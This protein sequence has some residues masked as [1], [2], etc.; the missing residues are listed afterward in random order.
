MR[1]PFLALTLTSFAAPLAAKGPLFSLPIDCDLGETC[2][3]QN[4]VDT[5]PGPDARDYTCGPLTYDGHKGTDF[6]VATIADMEAG[7]TVL[8]AAPGTVRA[9]RDG[10]SDIP[11]DAADAPELDGKD[12]GNGLVI[13]HG[14]GW[15]TQ[16][17]HMRNGSLE[18]EKGQRV[19]KGTHLGLIGLSGKTVFPHIHMSI[20]KH[21]EVVDPFAPDAAGTCGPSD[22]TLWEDPVAYQAGALLWVGFAEGIPDFADIKAG[23]PDLTTLGADAPGLVLWGYAFGTRAGDTMEFN[24]TGPDGW[25]HDQLVEFTKPQA[26]L[27]RASGR[28]RPPEGWPQGTYEG[29]VT[30]ARGETVLSSESLSITISR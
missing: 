3:I 2:F 4:Y 24:I 30:F 20:R 28:K 5:D 17:C 12:C 14:G 27:Y 29:K 6:R 16:Y 1:A 23:L 26:Q 25:R 9:T 21:G 15:E 10:M 11:S 18:V 8:A 7:V 19:A 22:S 13:D